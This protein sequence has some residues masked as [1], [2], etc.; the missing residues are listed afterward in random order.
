MIEA[1][2]LSKRH[3]SRLAVD[4][5]SFTVPDGAVTGLLGPAGAG[6]TTVLRL[7]VG[8]DRGSGLVLFDGVPF[9]ALPR[10]AQAVGAALDPR[11]LHPGRTALGHLRVL[12]AGAGVPRR[13]VGEVLERVGLV[14]AERARPGAFRRGAAQRLAV[15]GALLGRPRALLLDDPFAGLDD[16]DRAWLHG[17]LRRHAE[18]G[19]S[20]L[21]AASRAAD[22]VACADGLVVLRRGRLGARGPA[23][24]L[25]AGAGGAVLVRASDP[26]LLAGAVLRW[27]GAVT[28]EPDGALLVTG[29]D[30]A[31]VGEVARAEGV[32]VHELH[33]RAADLDAALQ[34][35]QLPETALLPGPRAHGAAAGGTAAPA[36]TA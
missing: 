20:A 9:A 36:V 35:L 14:G 7:A 21:V 16:D 15:A 17:L 11:A 3:G 1:L 4:D 31:A 10:P 27:G 2:A 26:G 6:K 25:L 18:A 22:V 30:M 24:E 29:L 23:A 8:L 13:R 34:S 32:A 12:A 19:G 28:P 33:Q 5:L